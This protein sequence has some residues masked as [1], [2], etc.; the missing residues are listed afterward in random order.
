MDN[1][2][3]LLISSLCY[4]LSCCHLR[5]FPTSTLVF[6]FFHGHH[7]DSIRHTIAV[8]TEGRYLVVLVEVV[9][10]ATLGLGVL[11]VA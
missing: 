3:D 5:H 10:L 1:G 6:L 4:P 7:G 2:S 9:G 8:G 11:M